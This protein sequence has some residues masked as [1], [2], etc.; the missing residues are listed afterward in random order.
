MSSNA[1]MR[2]N[3]CSRPH[4]VKIFDQKSTRTFKFQCRCMNS[5]SGTFK[6][7]NWEIVNA[8]LGE[9]EANEAVYLHE[10]QA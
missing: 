3:K 1:I 10:P 7:G 5:I 9:L 6:A 4:K 2:C 8:S